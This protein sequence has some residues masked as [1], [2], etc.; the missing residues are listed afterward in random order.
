ML[1]RS[2]ALGASLGL[3][4]SSLFAQD[5]VDQGSSFRSKSAYQ[6][7]L[8]ATGGQ[9]VAQWHAATLTPRAIYGTGL[10][11]ADWR[12]NSLEEAR[13]HALQA[14]EQHRGLLGL[15]TSEFRE[16]IGARMGRSW[17][18]K[19]DQYFRGVPCVGGRADV[20]VNMKGVIA[21]LGSQAWPIP[22]EF[23]TAPAIA[24]PVAQAIAWAEAGT[25]TGAVQ[26]APVA[27][28]RL[29]IW[30][31]TNASDVAP[32]FLAWEV[33]VSN[34]DAQGNGPIGR[35]YVDAKSGA[36]LHWQSDK[37]QCGYTACA[38]ASHVPARTEAVGPV[39]AALAPIPTTVTVMGWTRTGADAFS[40]L[41][42]TPMR[43]LVLNVP[44]IGNVTTDLNGEFTIDI[45]APVNIAVGALDG[46]HNNPISGA[47]APAGNFP[48][49]PG[50]NTTIQLLTAAATTNEAAHTTTQYWVDV[51][52]EFCRAILGNSGQLNTA[53]NVTTIVNIASTCNAFYTGNSINFYQ[54]GGGCSNTAFSTVIA[55]EWGHGL[56][57]RYGGIANS[58]TEGLS[59]GWGDIIG[60]YLVDSPNLGSGFQSPGTP[61]RSGN[62]TR[63]YPYSVAG[64]PH[65]A[66]E[67]WMG[68]AWKLRERLRAAIGTPAAIALSNDIVISTIAADATTRVDAVREVF[69]A[70]DDDGNLANG[71]PNYVHLSGAANDKAIPFPAIQIAAITHAPL[72]NTGVRLTPRIVNCTAAAVSSGSITQVRLNYNAGAG[73]VV[74][75][76]VPNGAANGYRALLPGLAS[77]SV[78]YY[79]E[80]VHS[81]GTTV[82]SPASGSYAYVVSVA[83]TGPFVGFYSEDFSAVTGWT[84]VRTSGTST[85]DWQRGAPNGKSGTSQG[86]GWSDPTAAA[87]NGSI[88]GTDLGAGAANGAYPANMN[89][90]L[91]SPIVN[92]TGR[93][94]MTLRFRRWLTVEEGIYDR[95]TVLVNGIAVWENP[96]NGNLIDTAWSTQ[97]IAIPAADNNAAVQ[98]EFRLITDGGL[99]LGG[100][101]V[102]DVELGTRFIAPLAA[103]LTMTPEQT[104]QGSPV[105]IA[106]QTDGGSKPFYLVL[107]DSAGPTVFAGVPPIL[108]GSVFVAV[109][110][111]TDPTGAWGGTFSAPTVASAN[112]VLWY[113]QVVTLDATN[114]TIVTSNQWLNLFTQ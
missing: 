87:S 94:G 77:G 5:P 68:F 59:E 72:G 30:G 112:G 65:P 23:G 43:G 62:N 8:T 2:F 12:G 98:I 32:F 55:H 17:T 101:N 96:Q 64:A 36:V 38:D 48:V 88:Y 99:Q 11:L 13:R 86:I 113:S 7:F 106:I 27:E 10:P 20:R 114:T 57:D 3:V 71:T 108:V 93:S 6:D 15:G 41:V 61:L 37:H 42:N 53:S 109:P 46:R 45:A 75:T 56:D 44:G 54:A 105:N 82:R 51:T 35:Y 111:T 79:I 81:G 31:D 92:C 110:S 50:V 76:M 60:L 28:P 83:P 91:R 103:E 29:V 22:A 26:P 73:N 58:V 95:A 33:A 107:G 89:Y 47:N 34:V 63:L 25:P 18:F 67:V 85:N 97:E 40:A 39:A 52:N 4:V 16:S 78:S 24:G 69:I 70:D 74:R 49:T 1:M 100:W 9:W 14:L 104:T 80:A 66:G 84:T 21:M 90:S 19:F 102:D